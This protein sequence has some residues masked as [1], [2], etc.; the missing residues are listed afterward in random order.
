[1]LYIVP[2]VWEDPSLGRDCPIV[3]VLFE[4][5]KLERLLGLLQKHVEVKDWSHLFSII[6]SGKDIMKYIFK[7]SVLKK[8]LFSMY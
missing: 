8:Y 5:Q 7:N 4:F 1:M 2:C 6:I 3:C